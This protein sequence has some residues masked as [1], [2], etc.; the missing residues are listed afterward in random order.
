MKNSFFAFLI[1][2]L[3][4]IN[5]CRSDESTPTFCST[6]MSTG[7]AETYLN[8]INNYNSLKSNF[9]T[10]DNT[11]RIVKISSQIT[12]TNSLSK[13]INENYIKVTTANVTSE[14]ANNSIKVLNTLEKNY[15]RLLCETP[16]R[17]LNGVYATEI[18][19]AKTMGNNTRVVALSNQAITL[20]Y[21]YLD[22]E[23]FKTTYKDA[24]KTDIEKLKDIKEQYAKTIIEYAG[25]ED[26]FKNN[27]IAK[28]LCYAID[29]VTGSF[30][31][32]VISIFIILIGM[33]LLS[34]QSEAVSFKYFI[35]TAIAL[36]LI[37]GSAQLADII[38]GNKYS[39]KMVNQK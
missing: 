21:G 13:K 30:G 10:D 27:G 9:E 6:N 8:L 3:C 5:V 11:D 20:I 33:S 36:A 12:A 31:K 32:T 15:V 22:R 7:I 37:F 35:S 39:C 28:A 2:F 29:L 19:K 38:S 24:C 26:D 1:C 25:G 16:I 14:C 17:E 23:E 34:G 18:E 4:L